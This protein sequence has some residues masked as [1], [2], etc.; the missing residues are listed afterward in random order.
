MYLV[1]FR[2]HCL[3][4]IGLLRK[5]NENLWFLKIS[6]EMQFEGNPIIFKETLV[7]L[8]EIHWFAKETNDFLRKSFA[9]QRNSI[10]LQ[11]QSFNK[12]FMEKMKSNDSPKRSNYCERQLTCF[13]HRKSIVLYMKFNGF[14]K[15]KGSLLLLKKGNSWGYKGSLLFAKGKTLVFKKRVSKLLQI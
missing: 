13:S 6:Q 12:C 2:I 10:E 5:C 11:M 14:Q 4:F 15:H 9:L 3:F 7:F 1:Y 8:K